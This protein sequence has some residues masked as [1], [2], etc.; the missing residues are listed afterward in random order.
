MKKSYSNLILKLVLGF[1]IIGCSKEDCLDITFPDKTFEQVTR[2]SNPY[3]DVDTVVFI[4]STGQ[5]YR[6][7]RELSFSNLRPN[8]LKEECGDGSRNITFNGDYTVESFIGPENTKFA[9]AYFVRFQENETQL[10]E[11]NIVDLLSISI[12]D[13]TVVSNILLNR[14]DYIT[15]N[16]G[17]QVDAAVQN[18]ANTLSKANLTLF[19]RQFNQI[20]EQKMSNKH[21][22]IFNQEFGLVSITNL[23]GK[24]L[25]F[26]RFIK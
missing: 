12:Y 23:D 9:F 21:K 14:L 11:S 17:G 19:G 4:D 20:I 18:D 25:V 26:D 13:A 15:S 22:I 24:K 16:K 10:I 7:M 1:M 2:S 5:E 3:V 8:I 6:F